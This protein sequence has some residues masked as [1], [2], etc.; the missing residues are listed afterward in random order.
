MIEEYHKKEG[1]K[2]SNSTLPNYFLKEPK[3]MKMA[4]TSHQT[5]FIN[6]VARGTTCSLRQISISKDKGLQDIIDFAY[7]QTK[8]N[9]WKIN[10]KSSI[11]S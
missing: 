6:L 2:R 5:H 1:E 9:E 4:M 3:K 10:R 7:G 11:H 8:Q